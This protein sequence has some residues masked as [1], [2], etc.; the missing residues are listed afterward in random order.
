MFSVLTPFS[1]TNIRY[2]FQHI[3]TF[4]VLIPSSFLKKEQW[5]KWKTP[6]DHHQSSIA[7]IYFH[8]WLFSCGNPDIITTP[9]A[10]YPPDRKAWTL[11]SLSQLHTINHVIKYGPN[12]SPPNRST[13]TRTG[14]PTPRCERPKRRRRGVLPSSSVLTWTSRLYNNIA[15]LQL[16][17]QTTAMNHLHCQI[18]IK[19]TETA[20][21][22]STNNWC[23]CFS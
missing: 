11:A 10:I 20:L 7:S 6:H 17:L 2:C 19:H 15:V 23:C 3:P 16:L 12:A 5:L 13:P 22:S 9:F 18:D 14:H 21:G 8:Y 4:P 1:R